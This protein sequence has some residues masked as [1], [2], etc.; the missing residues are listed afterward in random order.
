MH[1]FRS[2]TMSQ[3]TRNLAKAL[4][5]VAL[6]C[7]TAPV[8]ADGVAGVSEMVTWL[9]TG[10]DCPWGQE[11]ANP[12]LPWPIDK[13]PSNVRFDYVTSAHVYLPASFANGTTV[14]IDSG[15]ASLYAG[16]PSSVSHRVLA[17]LSSGE[18]YT[19]SELDDGEV[20]SVQSDGTFTYQVDIP[21]AP[22]E[23]EPEVPPPGTTSQVV[24]WT[25]TGADCPWG[26]Q[27]ANDALV[28]P[29]SAQAGSARLGYTTSKPI[30][31]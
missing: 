9:C 7:G 15:T 26:F 4:V 19:V 2:Q 21:E 31:L 16:H 11:L 3:F 27:L 14:W 5:P 29:D 24:T 28:W 18:F 13:N 17:T 8:F 6:A 22:A 12:A 30:Y 1:H 25:C 10:D 20:L 23:P